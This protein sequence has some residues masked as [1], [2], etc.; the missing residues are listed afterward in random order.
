M[1]I[2]NT[3]QKE[4]SPICKFTHNFSVIPVTAHAAFDKGCFYLN[5]EA[6][7]ARL[8]STYEVDVNH[9]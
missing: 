1:L 6:R 4:K 9:L 5:V 2:E 7:K 8:T 3:I